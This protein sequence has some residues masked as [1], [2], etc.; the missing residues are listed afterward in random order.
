MWSPTKSLIAARSLAAACAVALCLASGAALAYDYDSPAQLRVDLEERFVLLP[1]SDGLVLQ[2][3]DVGDGPR[4]VEVSGGFVALDGQ[5][6]GTDELRLRLGDEAAEMVLAAAELDTDTLRRL[7]TLE[8]T[9]VAP[10]APGA[11]LAEAAEDELE[12]EL[13][14]VEDEFAELSAAERQEAR[15]KAREALDKARRDVERA[16]REK[17]RKYRRTG[18]TEFAIGS[19]ITVDEGE[20]T[21]DLLVMGGFLKVEG[22]VDGDATV[23]GGSATIE[24]VVTGDLTA[25]GGPIRLED[26]AYVKGDVTSVGSRVYQDENAR[27]DGDV[28]Q[29]P[30]N[31]NFDF[32][33]WGDWR[34]WDRSYEYQVSPWHWWSGLGWSLVK[35]LFL[36]GLAWL[37]LLIAPGPIDRMERRI[38]AQPWKTGLVGLLAQVLF[39]PILIMLT[40]FLAIS[41]IGIPLLLILPFALLGLAIVAFLGFVAVAG[42]FGSWVEERFDW[43][44]GSPYW[45]VLLGL[46]VIFGLSLIGELLDF[47][48]APMRF[49]AGMFMFFGA[50]VSWAALTIGFGA[51]VLT[52]F[53]TAESWNRA[54]ELTAPL[55]TDPPRE[56]PGADAPPAEETDLDLGDITAEA[57][58]DPPPPPPEEDE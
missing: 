10:E 58:E 9:A 34:R 13:D 31:A 26:G 8:L 50:I 33:N 11:E 51:V 43:R 5:A 53:G 14:A 19:S 40:V 25:I 21:E 39:F 32:G 54:E 44:V 18:D 56:A 45:V 28:E 23:I 24:G 3:I 6:V 35:L 36:V 15:A 7:P 41:I 52:R 27:V 49:I 55:P 22:K 46:A 29:V 38:E 48:V 42:R 17:K 37:A 30:L 2:P 16:R 4:T 57:P 1:L 47:G 20:A 12:A